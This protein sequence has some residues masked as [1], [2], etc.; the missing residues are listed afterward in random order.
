MVAPR[1]LARANRHGLNKVTGRFADRLPGFGVVTHTGRKSGR[2]YRTP[3]NLFRTAHGY[4]V[5]L[6]YGPDS[7]W[8]RNVLAAG[9]CEI[10]TRGRTEQ[11]TD[12]ELRHDPSRA[13]MPTPVRTVLGVVGAEDF[14]HLRRTGPTA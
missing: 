9:G 3:V 6:T 7:D 2:R 14:L 10:T 8:V 5:A 1:W 4:Q 12:P 11:L 13:G